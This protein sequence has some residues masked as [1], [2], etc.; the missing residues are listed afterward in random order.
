[1]PVP[2]GP[3]VA[4]LNRE[5]SSP[6]KVGVATGHMLSLHPNTCTFSKKKGRQKGTEAWNLEFYREG[7]KLR[8]ILRHKQIAL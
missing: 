3:A 2:P 1:M 4:D 8:A 5:L 6:V 7:F